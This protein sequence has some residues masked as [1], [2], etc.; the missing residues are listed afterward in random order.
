M[1]SSSRNEVRRCRPLLG[2][3]VEICA[4]GGRGTD[5]TKAVEAA[6]NRVERV[7]Q[8]MSAHDPASELSRVNAEAFVRPIK[9]SDEM[10]EVL[11]RGLELARVSAGGFD[12]SIAPVLAVWGFLPEHLRRRN[13]GT[14]RDITLLPGNGVR[15]ARPLAIDLGGIAKGFAVDAAIAELRAR[16]VNAGIV[17]AGGD[18]RVFGR[19]ESQIHLRHPATAQPLAQPIPLRDAA[20]AT[21]SPCFTRQ[22]WRGRTVSHLVNECQRPLTRNISVSVR[23]G[24]CWLADALTKVVFNA[25]PATAARVLDAHHAE[26]FILTA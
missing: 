2:T 1:S 5:L 3:F 20:L 26:A 13:A 23:A 10:F 8:L 4:E 21:S 22:R 16:K 12:F 17:N 18:L 9:V 14:W 15:F 25:D 19:R 11:R 7:Q 24:E 6:F